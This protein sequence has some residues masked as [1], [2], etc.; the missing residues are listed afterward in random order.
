MSSQPKFKALIVGINKYYVPEH[1]LRGCEEDLRNVV[2]YVKDCAKE[3]SLELDLVHLLNETATRQNVIGQFQHLFKDPHPQDICLFYFSGHGSQQP[4]PMEFWDDH[5]K[6]L[7]LESLVCYDSRS[8]NGS[9]LADKELA[10]LVWSA[11]K[12]GMDNPFIMIIDSC[13]SGGADRD[14]IKIEE[15]ESFRYLRS[16]PL[17]SSFGNL[18]GSADYPKNENADTKL[19]PKGHYI[20]LSACH[21]NELAR[22]RIFDRKIQGAFTYFLLDTLRNHKEP[23]TYTDLL[24]KVRTRVMNNVED[25]TPQIISADEASLN[26]AF[27]L[28]LQPS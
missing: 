16:R 28:L 3:Q 12:N 20:M 13:H 10:W 26:Q 6:D 7:K 23:I 24:H 11:T 15:N 17:A 21:E 18:L 2:G 25:Q 22:E 8:A 9:D 14:P 1:N 19:A 4:A 27:P 5:H